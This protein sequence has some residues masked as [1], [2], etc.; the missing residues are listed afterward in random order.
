MNFHTPPPFFSYPSNIEINIG[1]ITLLQ[2][3]TPPPPP[4]FQ[5]L[6]SAPEE[7]LI[8]NLTN[9]RGAYLRGGVNSRIYGKF[10]RLRSLL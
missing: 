10:L 7:A 2:K 1:S 5:K 4:P 8:L 6:G 3:F 9:S